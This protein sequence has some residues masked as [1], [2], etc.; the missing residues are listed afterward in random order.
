MSATS[1]LNVAA[2][3]KS[4]LDYVISYS[5]LGWTLHSVD[6]PECSLV[7]GMADAREIETAIHDAIEAEAAEAHEVD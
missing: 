5:A 3:L 2:A 7:I 6:D 4:P 1:P